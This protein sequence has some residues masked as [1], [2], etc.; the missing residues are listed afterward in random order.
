[1]NEKYCLLN[2]QSDALLQSQL[3]L[4]EYTGLSQ[5]YSIDVYAV[6]CMLI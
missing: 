1:M 5:I 4:N 6:Q 3:D 2:Q